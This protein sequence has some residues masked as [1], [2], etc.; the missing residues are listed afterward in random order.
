MNPEALTHDL[1]ERARRQ[2]ID[3]CAVA[4]ADRLERDGAALE[5][6]LAEGRHAGMRWMA[7]DARA[8]TTTWISPENRIVQNAARRL[9]LAPDRS[10][11]VYARR[12]EAHRA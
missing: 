8:L 12:K 10:I 2:G 11:A 3:A 7:R 4:A 9:D 5:A 1:R 6:W